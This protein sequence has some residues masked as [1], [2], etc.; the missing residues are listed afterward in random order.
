[1]VTLWFAIAFVVAIRIA[2]VVEIAV[3]LGCSAHFGHTNLA[4]VLIAIK[5]A[6]LV[7]TAVSLGA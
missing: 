1:M 6:I 5:I 4:V 7:T 2:F 3:T